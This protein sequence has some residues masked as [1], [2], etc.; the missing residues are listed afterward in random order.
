SGGEGNLDP[1][2][3]KTMPACYFRGLRQKSPLT[4]AT[5]GGRSGCGPRP[6]LFH[7]P[8]LAEAF[9]RSPRMPQDTALLHRARIVTRIATVC[10]LATALPGFVS[11]A[12]PV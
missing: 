6:E 5:F 10:L 12:I 2:L 11:A 8:G 3:Q 9:I 1:P 4:T 7:P